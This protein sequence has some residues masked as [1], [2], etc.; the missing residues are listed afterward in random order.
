[1][2]PLNALIYQR[3]R[4]VRIWTVSGK[5]IDGR[6]DGPIDYWIFA[7]YLSAWSTPERLNV[8]SALH[9]VTVTMEQGR[10]ISPIA[11]AT[12]TAAPLTHVGLPTD[13]NLTRRT[14]TT[15]SS[16]RFGYAWPEGLGN[17]RELS[18]SFSTVKLL[19]NVLFTETFVPA[20]PG[21]VTREQF[22]GPKRASSATLKDGRLDGT[23]MSI[24]ADGTE[25]PSCFRDDAI[26]ISNQPCPAQ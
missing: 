18:T 22:F 21:I 10:V 13:G 5:C 7:N 3:V 6:L 12:R 4:D 19:G 15:I 24:G 2:K 17:G 11:L 26:V 23:F 25:Y 9:H 8:T 16:M 20:S 1:M 14:T